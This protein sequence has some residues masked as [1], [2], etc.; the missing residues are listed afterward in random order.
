MSDL[1]LRELERRGNSPELELARLRA[2]LCPGLGHA[3]AL[4]ANPGLPGRLLCPQFHY[5]EEKGE[6]L[7][8]S[9]R[10][11]PDYG[12]L[13]GV[14]TVPFTVSPGPHGGRGGS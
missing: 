7:A 9:Y 13:G 5:W 4:V 3:H 6:W 8:S 14:S 11:D 2:R 12:W 1:H 10:L